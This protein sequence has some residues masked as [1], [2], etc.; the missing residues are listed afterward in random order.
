[1]VPTISPLFGCPFFHISMVTLDWLHV[2]DLGV[3]LDFA[4]S[5]LKYLCDNKLHGTQDERY[6]DM[7][8]RMQL[9]YHAFD[10]QSRL[11]QFKPS[12]LV[13]TSRGQNAKY[14]KLRAK[15][16]ESR[17][18]VPFLVT[19]G[20]DL[21]DT[22]DVLEGQ[23]LHTCVAYNDCFQQLSRD[24]F[25]PA[26]L[27]DAADKFAILYVSLHDHCAKAHMALFKIKPKLHMFLEL[28]FEAETSPASTWTYRDESW[29]GEVSDM[30]ANKGGTSNPHAVGNSFLR[31][32]MARFPVPVL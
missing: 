20:R 3:S 27:R 28:C 4:G 5:I 19:V 22:S 31:R 7:H 23:M 6:R 30:A 12:M 9:Y 21:L 18:L 14:P 1:M 16:G 2:V 8:H 17:A 26:R 13:K 10:V 25:Q 29:G 11:D 32:F 15:A 24:T